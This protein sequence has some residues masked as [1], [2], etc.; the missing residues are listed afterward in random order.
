VWVALL[1][2]DIVAGGEDLAGAVSAFGLAFTRAVERQREEADPSLSGLEGSAGPV[3]AMW[4]ETAD[5]SPYLFPLSISGDN[6]W[7]TI[8]RSPET[9]TIPPVLDEQALEEGL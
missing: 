9:I 3:A 7:V 5:A 2:K 4:L 1:E 6:Y 8:K